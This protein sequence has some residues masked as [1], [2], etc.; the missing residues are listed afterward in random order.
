MLEA[1]RARSSLSPT[2][3]GRQARSRSAC[4]TW[5][6]ARFIPQSGVMLAEVDSAERVGMQRGAEDTAISSRRLKLHTDYGHA[7]MW[8]KGFA[9]DEISAAY[10]QAA[11]FA[12]PAED[13]AARFVAYYAEC[14]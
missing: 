2:L 11:K 6:G 7:T 12:G 9:A 3:T 5:T 8:L 13:A 10:A 14:A 4:S 1:S